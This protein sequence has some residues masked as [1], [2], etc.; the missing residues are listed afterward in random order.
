MILT[1]EEFLKFFPII[2]ISRSDFVKKMVV[3][4]KG[5]P[6]LEDLFSLKTKI[7]KSTSDRRY[8]NREQI[9]DYLYDIIILNRHEYL[10]SFYYA[11]FEFQN[12]LLLK[13]NG[14]DITHST[15]KSDT[16]LKKLLEE[17]NTENITSDE[18]NN[19]LDNDTRVLSLQKNDASRRLVRNLNFLEI[20][21]T[22]KVT[23][24]CK[25]KTSF[26]KSLTDV[27]NDLILADRMFAPSSLDQF[28]VEKNKSGE[29]NYN[30]F[31]Y[32]F[33]GYQPKAS[34]LNPY[35]ISY[36]LKNIIHPQGSSNLKLFTPVLSWCSYL[37]SFLHDPEW[38]HY[39]GIDVIPQVIDRCNF[40]N[41]YYKEKFNINKYV[42]LYC[43]PSESFINDKA[44][45]DKYTNYFDAIIFCPPY[46]DMEI[47]QDGKQALNE[48]P[49]YSDWLE[50]YWHKTMIL[51]HK[52]LNKQGK[53][54]FI[55]NNY[56]TL[57]GIYYDLITDLN[58]IALKYFKLEN[59]VELHARGSPL[60]VNHKKRTEMLFLYKHK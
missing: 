60:R 35:T 8:I 14:I 47:Y 39:V 58:M 41:N 45:L 37:F 24:T 5:N 55:I 49:K 48:Y 13:W 50:N 10:T 44:F 25:S 19:L 46:Y 43:R 20:L 23:N 16:K 52:V 26:W 53:L 2:T 36:I 28:F 11:Y 17:M 40:L 59:F 30:A 42:D 6:T 18:F 15:S 51:C 31:F 12:P 29:I 3:T 32:L 27:Y 7:I 9:I 54:S 56:N 33:Q 22:T 1:L 21:N 38:S 34:I 57:D 4:Y